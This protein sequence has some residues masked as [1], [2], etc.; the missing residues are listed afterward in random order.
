MALIDDLRDECDELYAFVSTIPEP[1]W[2]KPTAFWG[3]TTFD[4]IMH[5]LQVDRFALAS[6]TDPEAFVALRDAS[7][8]A[9][10]AG[11]ELSAQA[12]AEF[13]HLAMAG[14]LGV[15]REHYLQL[16]DRLAARDATDRVAWFG[17]DMAVSSMITARQM[18]VWAHGQDLY[19]LFQ[20]RRA[21]TGRL[22]NIC[23]LGV[24][25]FG[26]SF[27]NRG[28][29]RPGPAPRVSLE[30]PKREVWEWNAG[31]PGTVSGRAEDFA[32]VV[33]QRRSVLDTRLRC[34]GAA[35]TAWM[36][37]AQCFAGPPADGPQPGERAWRPTELTDRG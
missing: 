29:E 37:I 6:A 11:V 15:W 27:A 20:V 35:A 34:D 25:T 17:P 18:E 1:D 5:L 3:W 36:P 23:D 12:R 21:A 4:Q 31:A 7:R 19:D 16:C 2:R 33:T 8:A 13:G 28:L 22:R 26:W 10:Q 9:S 30:G 24:R 14:L 32:L